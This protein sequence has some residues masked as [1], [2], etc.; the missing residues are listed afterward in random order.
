LPVKVY[1]PEV[2]DAKLPIVLLVQR[3]PSES[4]GRALASRGF[5]TLQIASD[6]DVAFALDVLASAQDSNIDTERIAIVGARALPR[7]R[8]MKAIIAISMPRIESEHHRVT[9]EDHDPHPIAVE[10]ATIALLRALLLDDRE[11]RAW[12]DDAGTGELMGM[13]VAVTQR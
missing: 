6:R 1:A 11:M 5:Y 10:E 12:L 7:D 3:D 4:L 9:F 13:K 8:R 2:S